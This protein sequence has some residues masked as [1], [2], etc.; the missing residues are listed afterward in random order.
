Q[1]PSCDLAQ[2]PHRVQPLSHRGGGGG[3]YASRAH[4]EGCPREGAGRHPT[5]G[6]YFLSNGG[7][8][9]SS[10]T[11]DGS[12]SIEPSGKRMVGTLRIPS[13]SRITSSAATAFSSILI[14]VYSTPSAAK[15]RF[16]RRQSPHQVVEYMRIRRPSRVGCICAASA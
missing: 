9:A 12:T 10:A 1:G 13:F 5:A 11:L 4:V 14:S 16:A 7:S 3:G 2:Q 8:F 15:T 6:S